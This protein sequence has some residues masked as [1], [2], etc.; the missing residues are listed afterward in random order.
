MYKCSNCGE[1]FDTKYLQCPKCGCTRGDIKNAEMHD[2]TT[3]R[4]GGIIAIVFVVG[5]I[6]IICY[7]AY[8][9]IN[10]FQQ[11]PTITNISST[12]TTE[13]TST[14]TISTTSGTKASTTTKTTKAQIVGTQS[15]IGAHKYTVPEGYIEYPDDQP[16]SLLNY[17]KVDIN[18]KVIRNAYNY[19]DVFVLSIMDGTTL[20]LTNSME[21]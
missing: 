4:I 7:G 1:E 18:S 2:K 6:G 13:T 15:Q 11:G 3:E 9:L 16:L 10:P 5:L 14:D 21:R 19:N 17:F 20:K 8:L 12:T